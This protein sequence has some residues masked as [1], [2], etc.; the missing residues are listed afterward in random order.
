MP[1]LI[2]YRCPHCG[3]KEM[4]FPLVT[5]VQNPNSQ[6]HYVGFAVCNGCHAGISIEILASVG[7]NPMN[8]QG[9]LMNA[10]KYKVLAVHPTREKSEAPE[11]VGDSVAK[12]FIQ[13]VESRVAGH[14]DAAGAMYR[15]ALDVALKVIDPKLTGTL[16][17]RIEKLA[18]CH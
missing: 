1:A 15:K 10:A 5:A 18:S 14:Y 3:T 17:A 6:H 9:N 2:T 7:Q 12:P 4:H 11:H 8:Y 13:A 16:Y